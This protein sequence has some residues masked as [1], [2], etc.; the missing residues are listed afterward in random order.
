MVISLTA[1]T[2]GNNE[3]RKL[4]IRCLLVIWNTLLK[5][6][7]SLLEAAVSTARCRTAEV[8]KL[9]FYRLGEDS[10]S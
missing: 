10:Y 6:L 1:V 4:K 8:L 5:H 7:S 2:E 3:Q 9:N